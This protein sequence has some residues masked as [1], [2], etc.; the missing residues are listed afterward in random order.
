M[1]YNEIHKLTKH[2]QVSGD[3]SFYDWTIAPSLLS[4]EHAYS[5]DWLS[6]GDR[7]RVYLLVAVG[8]GWH[9]DLPDK[10]DLEW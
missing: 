3:I 1:L 7:C 4:I 2:I 6:E 10:A 8:S 5:P 9:I